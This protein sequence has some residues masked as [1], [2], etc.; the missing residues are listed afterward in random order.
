MTVPA[1]GE[2]AAGICHARGPNANIPPVWLVY[3]IVEDL[4]ESLEEVRGGGG[5]ILVGP[6]DMGPGAAYAVIRDPAGAGA[7]LYQMGG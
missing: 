3:F 6:K 5:E 1:T 2:P 7:A 4:A